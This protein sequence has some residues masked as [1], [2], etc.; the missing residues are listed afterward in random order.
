MFNNRDEVIRIRT[1]G[2]RAEHCNPVP[3]V[4][5]EVVFPRV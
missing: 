4:S 5:P 1:S 3:S 2:A